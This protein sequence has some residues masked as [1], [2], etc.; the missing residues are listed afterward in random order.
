MACPDV[1]K[2]EKMAVIITVLWEHIAELSTCKCINY[3][4]ITPIN[5]ASQI[6][7][8]PQYANIELKGRFLN[9]PQL[10]LDNQ[11]DIQVKRSEVSS[12]LRMTDL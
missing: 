7:N 1:N 4:K 8:L 3:D 11:I 5:E 6:K 10:L 2:N 12:H 9:S